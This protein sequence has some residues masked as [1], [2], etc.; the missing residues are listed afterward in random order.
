MR[1]TFPVYMLTFVGYAW[2]VM[3]PHMH[4]RL[5]LFTLGVSF[6]HMTCKMIVAAM[7]HIDYPI[8]QSSLIP[9]PVIFFITKLKLL[10]R[11]DDVLL[12]VYTAVSLYSMCKWVKNAIEEIS[13]Y[14]GIH[15]FRLGP[16]AKP[17]DK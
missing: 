17:K 13:Q 10:P 3:I 4:P 9:L 1:Q 11:H 5:V 12:G 8:F 15:T 16:R 14:I 6:S 7:A 2:S